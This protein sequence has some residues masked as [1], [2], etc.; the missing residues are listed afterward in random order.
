MWQLA[1][2]GST[3]VVGSNPTAFPSPPS[4]SMATDHGFPFAFHIHILF[5]QQ[6]LTHLTLKRLA[7]LVLQG[8]LNTYCYIILFVLNINHNQFLGDDDIVSDVMLLCAMIVPQTHRSA[9]THR[10]RCMAQSLK[11]LLTNFCIQI[12]DTTTKGL[13][14]NPSKGTKNLFRQN[15]TCMLIIKNGFVNE[16]IE[17]L[18]W[19]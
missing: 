18:V 1:R 16:F 13:F 8:T 5:I 3:L 6:L 14:P 9:H 4:F 19:S 11:S 10:V 15:R 2:R 7:I 12:Y 17:D